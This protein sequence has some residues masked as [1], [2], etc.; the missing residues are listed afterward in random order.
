MSPNAKVFGHQKTFKTIAQSIPLTPVVKFIL[1]VHPPDRWLDARCERIRRSISKVGHF[2]T[3]T[4]PFVVIFP[5]KDSF[6]YKVYR[7]GRPFIYQGLKVDN[8]N[9]NAAFLR[10]MTDNTVGAFTNDVTDCD[11]FTLSYV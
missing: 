2:S 9:P 6:V 10:T 4:D 7:K 11:I 3:L 5:P 8:N 1:Q